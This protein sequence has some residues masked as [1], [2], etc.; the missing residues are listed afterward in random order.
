MAEAD[1]FISNNGGVEKILKEFW[2]AL[3]EE[4][5][6]PTQMEIDLLDLHGYSP[7]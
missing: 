4:E 7:A 5:E 6:N 2:G 3:V 1:T